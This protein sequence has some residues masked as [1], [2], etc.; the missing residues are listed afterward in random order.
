LGMGDGALWRAGVGGG[1]W[2]GACGEEGDEGGL[3][4]FEPCWFRILSADVSCVRTHFASCTLHI[5]HAVQ[6]MGDSRTLYFP[7][8][9]PSLHGLASV[10]KRQR[11]GVTA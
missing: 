9:G 1:V 4:E 8:G 6:K 7:T 3:S 2:G 5:A 10:T 11:L